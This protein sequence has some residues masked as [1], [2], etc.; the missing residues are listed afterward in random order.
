MKGKSHLVINATLAV[1]AE[2]AFHLAGSPL[3]WADL[4]HLLT[5]LEDDRTSIVISK[6]IYYG[7]TL[8]V[9]RLPD[10][11][12][13]L[14]IVVGRHRG[15]THSL[16]GGLLFALTLLVIGFLALSALQTQGIALSP[17][18]EAMGLLAISATTL[19]CFYHMFADS[20]TVAGILFL[21]PAN[22]RIRLLPK[23]Q[24]IR[25]GRMSEYLFVTSWALIVSFLLW[26][27]ILGF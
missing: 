18:V 23:G 2:N 12:L 26:N 6:G 19:S 25:T 5:H 21:W 16:L 3:H 15:L 10:L 7:C 9:A 8:L 27:N 1:I 11:D 17:Q 24:R 20:F 13:N 4:I 14:R 22:R